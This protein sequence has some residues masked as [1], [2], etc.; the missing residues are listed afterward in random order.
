[1]KIK[2]ASVTVLFDKEE[3]RSRWGRGENVLQ[4]E[5]N[6]IM[7]HFGAGVQWIERLDEQALSSTDVLLAALEAQDERTTRILLQYIERGGIVI[8]YGGLSALADRFGYREIATDVGYACLP[9]EMA[10]SSRPL[11]Y[12]R[13]KPWIAREEAGNAVLSGHNQLKAISP[14]GKPIA[15]AL[16]RLELGLGCV[17]RWAIDIPQTIVHFQQ[18]SKPV[19]EDG[20]PAPD[21]SANVDEGILKADDG[22][23]M[24]WDFDRLV[25]DADA[26][27]FAYPYADYWKEALFEHLLQKVTERGLTLPFVGYW[28]EGVRG[29]A[30]LSFDSD[31]NMDEQGSTTLDVLQTHGVRTTWCMLEPGYTNETYKRATVEGHEL[32][33]HYNARIQ[34]GYVWSEDEFQRQLIGLRSKV[35]NPAIISNK[36]HFTRFEGW[37]EL[38]R[39]CEA[40]GIECDQTRGP[41]KR[42]NVG[43][44]FGTC[45]PY[46]P[47]ALADE[48]NRIYHVLEVGFLTQDLNVNAATSDRSIISPL[49][50]EV[51]AVEG[52]AH[53]LFHQRHIHRFEQVRAALAEVV[54]EARKHG[55]EFWTSMQINAWIRT[56]ASIRVKAV[57]PEGN[58]TCENNIRGAV[59]WTPIPD[60]EGSQAVTEPGIEKKFGVWC[61]KTVL[62]QTH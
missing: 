36:N 39:W 61:K 8:S 30:L 29:V 15:A 23:E 19:I 42:G 25:T 56:R 46:F 10:R 5:L 34:E 55:Y 52:V 53:F 33:Y 21:G 6:E 17:E 7:R 31:D 24:D 27:Y 9:Q 16:L 4:Y 18:G 57:T 49:F 3:A 22:V 43:F 50:E 11:R 40:A 12:L 26:P 45:H 14:D 38:F 59:I 60:Y 20:I 32:A 47:I 35:P 41:S 62:P 2:I 48:Q 1:M 51:A 54:S 58:I 37:G 13:A 28:P 44:L